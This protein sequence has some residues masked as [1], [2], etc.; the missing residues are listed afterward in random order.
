MVLLTCLLR[1]TL[2]PQG[3][4]AG[5]QPECF[6]REERLYTIRVVTVIHS[7]TIEAVFIAHCA[8]DC[9]EA[10]IDED[11]SIQMYS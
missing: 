4:L 5:P 10:L 8:T 7:H 2:L 9:K 3:V 11:N 1:A 6:H